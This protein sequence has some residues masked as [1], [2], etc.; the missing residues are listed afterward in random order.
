M[1]A[2][3]CEVARSILSDYIYGN[4]PDGIAYIFGQFIVAT[5]VCSLIA[6]PA[7]RLTY[8]PAI[9]LVAAAVAV[10]VGNASKLGESID[11]R[12]GMKADERPNWFAVIE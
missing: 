9:V 1:S 4:S 5:I 6:I 2:S 10:V 7:R 11:G 12:Q 8:T 3:L